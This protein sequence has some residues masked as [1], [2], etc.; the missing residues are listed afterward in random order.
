MKL[1]LTTAWHKLNDWLS[2][3]FCF[4]VISF[5]FFDANNTRIVQWVHKLWAREFTDADFD[6]RLIILSIYYDIK[7][8]IQTK[9]LRA[10]KILRIIDCL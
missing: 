1:V 10:L 8:T 9:L 2:N 4:F 5:N 7:Y 6:K 3:M